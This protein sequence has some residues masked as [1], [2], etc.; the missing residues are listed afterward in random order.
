MTDDLSL[1]SYRN[2]DS[3]ERP[4]NDDEWLR[5]DS[6]GIGLYTQYTI[7]GKSRILY[8]GHAVNDPRGLA[9]EGWRIPS[10]ENWDALISCLDG[11]AIAGSKLKETGVTNWDDQNIG[12]TNSS[13]FTAV[14]SGFREVI[15]G[16]I[17]NV[18]IAAVYWASALQDQSS[19]VSYKSIMLRNDTTKISKVSMSSDFGLSVRCLRDL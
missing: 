2:G 6:N 18:G 12:A 9:P 19:D 5:L 4:F 11:Y 1:T 14:A 7:K 3:I 8:N 16:V 17:D 10:I 13:G 15:S